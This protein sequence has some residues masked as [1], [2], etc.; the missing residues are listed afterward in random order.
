MAL[1]NVDFPPLHSQNP[2][3]YYITDLILQL[4]YAVSLQCSLS[5]HWTVPLLT[6][7]CLPRDTQFSRNKHRDSFEYFYSA[8]CLWTDFVI[9]IALEPLSINSNSIW[10]KSSVIHLHAPLY[11]LLEYCVNCTLRRNCKYFSQ[12]WVKVKVGQSWIY[13]SPYNNNSLDQE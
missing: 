5:I 7:N 11:F 13:K 10:F 4:Y 1:I 8:V 9:I 6:E 3:R 12:L 2:F